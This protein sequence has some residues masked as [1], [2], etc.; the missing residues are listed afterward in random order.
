VAVDHVTDRLRDDPHYL[1]G[2]LSR[3]KISRVSR[4]LEGTYV[5][6]VFAA[7]ESALR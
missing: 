5:V 2:S 6:R 4:N 1:E 3:E 7:F